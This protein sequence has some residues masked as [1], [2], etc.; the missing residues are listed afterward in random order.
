MAVNGVALAAVAAGGLFVYSGVKGYSVPQA[1]QN[2]I[3][4]HPPGSAQAVAPL[5]SAPPGPAPGTGV[6]GTTGS[7]VA[8]TALK[9][10]GHAYLFGGAPGADGR[11][12]WDCS[13]FVNWVLGHDLGMTLPGSSRGGYDGSSHGPTT[14]S[15][16]A[17]TGARTIGHSG[18]VAAPGDLCVWQTHMGIAIGGGK[19]ISARD[20]A[21][22]TG[23]DTI[24]GDIPGE[25][26]FVRRIV[27]HG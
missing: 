11:G 17:W 16:L 3:L 7:A 27:T 26:L 2:I 19:M 24:D 20:P 23:I 6:P 4:G 21:E 1:A 22:G 9:Y 13:S 12:P 5:Y 15:Y 18:A 8:D 10:R 25:L 14:L